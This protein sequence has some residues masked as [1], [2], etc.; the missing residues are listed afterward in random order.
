MVILLELRVS[1][2]GFLEVVFLSRL[3]LVED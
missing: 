3:L 2:V 1:T